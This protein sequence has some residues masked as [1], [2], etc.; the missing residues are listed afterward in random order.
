[1]PRHVN[2]SVAWYFIWLIAV[3]RG[4]WLTGRARRAGLCGGRVQG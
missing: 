1:M 3:R 4:Q 2:S